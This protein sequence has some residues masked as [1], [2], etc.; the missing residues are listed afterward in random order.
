VV[1]QLGPK[2]LLVT[3]GSEQV[4]ELLRRN[5]YEN[6]GR[7]VRRVGENDEEADGERV[8]SYGE[9][10]GND[11]CDGENNGTKVQ[12]FSLS[13]SVDEEELKKACDSEGRELYKT[14]DV[15][16]GSDV[17]YEYTTIAPVLTTGKALL[18]DDCSAFLVLAY[19]HR[20]EYLWVSSLPPLSSV[21]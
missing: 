19:V 2:E 17:I 6:L 7:T 15:V 4:M 9:E 5:I 14:C 1:A 11:S 12:V 16:F 10:S 3:D 20:S 8:C 21:G 18:S 13:W